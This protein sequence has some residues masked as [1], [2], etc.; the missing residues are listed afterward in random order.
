VAQVGDS[1][2]NVSPE[3]EDC[4]RVAIEKKVP[5]KEVIE[6]VRAAALRIDF[7]DQSG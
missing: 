4:K 2:I 6:E 3:Y 5:L 1:A 7:T